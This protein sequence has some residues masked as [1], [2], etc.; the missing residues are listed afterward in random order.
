MPLH[1]LYYPTWR[2]RFD[3][4]IFGYCTRFDLDAFGKIRTVFGNSQNRCSIPLISRVS[5]TFCFVLFVFVIHWL[6][7]KMHPLCRSNLFQLSQQ[8]YPSTGTCF[9]EMQKQTEQKLLVTFLSGINVKCDLTSNKT[10][11]CVL[12]WRSKND[13]CRIVCSLYFRC[14]LHLHHKYMTKIF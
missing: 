13:S 9:G 1:V 11:Y 5:R 10:T 4:S 3:N 2:S 12:A 7:I 6:N 8:G 14:W